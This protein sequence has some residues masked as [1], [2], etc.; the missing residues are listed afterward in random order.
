MTQL[1][2][3]LVT[4]VNAD[5]ES[6]GLQAAV[7]NSVQCITG[8]HLFERIVG[9]V[10]KAL[11]WEDVPRRCETLAQLT[12][13]MVKMVGY[14][15]R[16]PRWRFVLVLDAIDGQRDAPPTLLP[17]LARLSEIVSC[18]I[19]YIG[20]LRVEANRSRSL[21]LPASSSSR[22]LPQASY[23][24]LHQHISTSLPTPKPNSFESSPSHHQV[25]FW[26]T[27]SKRRQISGHA[28]ALRSTTR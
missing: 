2:S 23:D 10:A 24:H 3:Q 27:H 5:A 21:A 22:L 4:S 6:G 9:E 25:P 15:E 13:E 8:R 14:P 20:C 17:A 7:V 18:Y 19:L 28:S 1:V 16:D 12:V 26:G 11:E